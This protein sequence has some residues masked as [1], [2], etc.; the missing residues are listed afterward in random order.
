MGGLTKGKLS[1]TSYLLK[2]LRSGSRTFSQHNQVPL[3]NRLCGA[4]GTLMI[5]VDGVLVDVVRAT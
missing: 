2:S 5:R 4:L 3:M 1:L